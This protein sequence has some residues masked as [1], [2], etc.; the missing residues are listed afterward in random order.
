MYSVL[1]NDLIFLLVSYLYCLIDICY[2]KQ[3]MEYNFFYFHTVYEAT[4]VV[5]LPFL[6]HVLTYGMVMAI[7]R[8]Y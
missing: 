2:Y 6:V 1:E 8:L 3:T 5:I 4:G 7:Y